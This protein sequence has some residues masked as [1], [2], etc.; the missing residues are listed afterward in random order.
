MS[1]A[2]IDDENARASSHAPWA[3]KDYSPIPID[4]PSRLKTLPRSALS[5]AAGGQ[6]STISSSTKRKEGQAGEFQIQPKIA[7]DLSDGTGAVE[8]RGELCF[9]H[10]KPQLLNALKTIPRI[11]GNPGRVIIGLVGNILRLDEAQACSTSNARRPPR[12]G[13]RW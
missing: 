9:G 4:R 3:G 11:S 2:D 8:L 7:R 1:A 10:G 13:C 5:E 12:R 6:H